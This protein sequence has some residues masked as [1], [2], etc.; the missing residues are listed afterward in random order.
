MASRNNSRY[1]I[2]LSL[3]LKEKGHKSLYSLKT[4]SISEASL[5]NCITEE[6]RTQQIGLLP[7]VIFALHQVTRVICKQLKP[8]MHEQT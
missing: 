8:L 7:M 6:N 2:Q 3:M 5:R 4:D 1:Y